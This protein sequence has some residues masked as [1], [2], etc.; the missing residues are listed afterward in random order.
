MSGGSAI[1]ADAATNWTLLGT[2]GQPG[3]NQFA[4]ETEDYGVSSPIYSVV[5]TTPTCDTSFDDAAAGCPAAAN[6]STEEEVLIVGPTTSSDS[7][8]FTVTTTWTAVP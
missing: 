3:A 6:Q 2:L 4:E 5:S 8:P 7:G 1:P